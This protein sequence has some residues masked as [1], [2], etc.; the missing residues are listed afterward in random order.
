M[1]WRPTAV[2]DTRVEK[3]L[4]S[5]VGVAGVH[6]TLDAQ[7]VLQRVSILREGRIQEHQLIRN[8]VSALKAGLGI[9]LGPAQVHVLADEESWRRAT[10]A[11]AMSPADVGLAAA[12]SDPQPGHD[13]QP[14]ERNGGGRQ[15]AGNG[16][17]RHANGN[18][19]HAERDDGRNGNGVHPAPADRLSNGAAARHDLAS[20]LAGADRRFEPIPCMWPLESAPVELESITVERH[21]RAIRCRVTVRIGGG[22]YSAAAETH[23]SPS[24]EADLAARVT[25][26]ALRAGGL[27]STRLDGVSL[28]TIADTVYVVAAVRSASSTT[29]HASAAPLDRNLAAAAAAAV[30]RAHGTPDP[31]V[32]DPAAGNG[33]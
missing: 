26:D 18:G 29:P 10:S 31:L 25:L 24:A 3:L 32:R 1:S 20:G 7:R 30:L 13:A 15:Y 17:G 11:S 21:A 27:T 33:T 12:E 8:V 22:A 16:N 23:D 2:P 28:T 9:H 5:V 19:K 6:V 14:P 4:R